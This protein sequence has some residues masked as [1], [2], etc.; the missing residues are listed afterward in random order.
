[1]AVIALIRR[2]AKK[3]YV[4]EFLAAYEKERPRDKPGFITEY[5]TRVEGANL[6]GL[7]ELG[8]LHPCTDGVAFLNVAF[9]ESEEAFIA[10]FNPQPGYFE[11]ETECE[12]RKRAILHIESMASSLPP[13]AGT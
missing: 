10:A 1:M 6:P 2:V 5:L 13:K 12:P 11:S 4:D 7:R 9:W 8:L 3:D